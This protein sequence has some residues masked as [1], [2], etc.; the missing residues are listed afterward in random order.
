M[1]LN[2]NLLGAD[3]LVSALDAPALAKSDVYIPAPVSADTTAK[4]GENE[5]RSDDS[6]AD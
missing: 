2:F 1:E 5:L 6:N 3:L 4:D